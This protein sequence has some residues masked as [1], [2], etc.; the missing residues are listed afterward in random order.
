MLSNCAHIDDHNAAHVVNGSAWWYG[1]T[2]NLPTMS[3]HQES[4]DL[5]RLPLLKTPHNT[6]FNSFDAIMY[7]VKTMWKSEDGTPV[8]NEH[9]SLF[10]MTYMS[11]ARQCRPLLMAEMDML[12]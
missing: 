12:K 1:K 8:H 4:C 9:I 11:H 10:V 2:R 5:R 3:A 6:C 7:G